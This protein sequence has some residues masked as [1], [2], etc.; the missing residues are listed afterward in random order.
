MS[1]NLRQQL[2][3]K[4][5]SLTPKLCTT[6][7]QKIANEIVKKKIFTKSQNIACYIPMENEI[8][9]WPIIKT[10]WQLGKN[11]Y[12]PTIDPTKKYCLRFIKFNEHDEL[13]SLK[14]KIPQPKID[15]KKTL[16]PQDLDLA[17]VPLVGFND[18]LFRLGRGAGYY[19]RAF[20]FKIK[21]NE[22]K[23][24]LLGVGYEWQ[25]VDFKSKPWDVAMDEICI[26]SGESFRSCRA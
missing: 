18:D 5:Q 1:D 7:S 14:Y 6:T 11:C 21:K 3:N 17:I 9:I 10:L 4:L 2:R 26:G 8:D 25:R 15:H 13:I 16:T 22:S 23:P 24:Y 12:L 20:E 19:D